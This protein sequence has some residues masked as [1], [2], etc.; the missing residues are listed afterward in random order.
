LEGSATRLGA[1]LFD[2]DRRELLRGPDA[3]HLSPKAF[4]LLQVLIESAPKAVSKQRLYDALWPDLF[5][6]EANLKNL[7]SEIRA[8]LGETARSRGRVRTVHGFGYAIRLDEAAGQAPASVGSPCR[9]RIVCLGREVELPPGEHI[10][11]R[12][13]GLT[14]TIPSASVSRRHARLVISGER[15]LLE[16]LGSKNGTWL[17]GQR[18]SGPAELQDGAELRLGSISLVVRAVPKGT[19]KTDARGPSVDR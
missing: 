2:P 8:A 16:D 12:D 7:V 10:L 11:G 14:L 9:F 1:Y 3:V 18:L 5:V 6:E 13:D 19:T 17:G 4:Q 15:A